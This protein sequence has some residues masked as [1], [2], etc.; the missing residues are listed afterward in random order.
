MPTRRAGGQQLPPLAAEDYVCE[1]CGLAYLD[2]SIDDAVEAI[3]SLPAAVRA[4]VSAIPAEVR[5]VRPHPSEWSVTEYV[6]HLRDIYMACTIRLHRVRTEE[7]P[8]LEPVF[9]DLRARRFR[10][11]ER[12]AAAVIDEV[13]S[14]IAGCCEEIILT[15]GQEWDRVATRLPGEQR[16][17][18]WLLRQAMHEGV[19]HLADIR[20]IGGTAGRT[21]RPSDGGGFRAGDRLSRDEVHDRTVR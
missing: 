18:R 2:I 9:N 7:R 17:A 20:R 14:A 21:D 16:S 8:T 1:S 13:T 19:H 11:N 3:T 10:Y 4:A 15:V 5:R 12:D 6:C